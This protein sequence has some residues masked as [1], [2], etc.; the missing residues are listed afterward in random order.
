MA[1][2]S[3][4]LLCGGLTVCSPLAAGPSEIESHCL[5]DMGMTE[6]ER[7]AVLAGYKQT[8]TE[9]FEAVYEAGGWAWPLFSGGF[10]RNQPCVERYRYACAAGSSNYHQ[11]DLNLYSPNRTEPDEPSSFVDPEKDVAE[12]LLQRGPWAYLGTGWVGC[13]PAGGPDAMGSN[14]TSYRRPAAW[15]VD[16]GEPLG[17]CQEEPSSSGVFVREWTKA[18]VSIDCRTE[19]TRIVMKKE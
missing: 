8:M 11:T 14:D 3:N 18:T 17:L 1:A 9:A 6:P 12:F 15:D 2:C 10:A 7:D 13:A 5:L 19:E 16:Y 4:S